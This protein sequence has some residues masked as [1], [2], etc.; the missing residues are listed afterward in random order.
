MMVFEV[1]SRDKDLRTGSARSAQEPGKK[2]APRT[3]AQPGACSLQIVYFGPV[4]GSNS[5]NSRNP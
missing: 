1:G 3:Y 4:T 5:G 2:E